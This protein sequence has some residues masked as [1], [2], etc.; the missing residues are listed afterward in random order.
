[1]TTG[2]GA[3]G[4][5]RPAPLTAAGVLVGLQG[6]AGIAYG[7]YLGV[8][9]LVDDPAESLV[10][11]ELGALLLVAGGAG[12]L[13]CARGLLGRRGW[14]R[15][16]VITVQLLAALL[17]FNYLQVPS[18]GPTYGVAVL[19]LAGAVLYALATPAARLAFDE[20]A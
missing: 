4:P 9:A 17:G 16:P 5:G 8:R 19:V 15:A 13:A 18:P 11:A 2:S 3:G 12:L 14:A 20:D 7:A 6:L 10:G 1:M